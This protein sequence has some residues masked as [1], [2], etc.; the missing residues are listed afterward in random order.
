[1]SLGVVK[2]GVGDEVAEVGTLV[3]GD[4][5]LADI[6]FDGAEGGTGFVFEA[7]EECLYDAFLEVVARILFDDLLPEFGRKVVE[8]LTEDV[9]ADAGEEK[10]YFRPHVLGDTRCGVERDGL[11]GGLNLLLA[12]VVSR[13]ELA[14]GI[15]SINLEALGG[16]GV[17]LDEAEVVKGGA[18]VEK[19]GVKAEVLLAALFGRKEIDA[20]RVVVEQ[21][22]ALL[23]EDLGGFF[24]ELGVGD[25]GSADGEIH[26][27]PPWC[28]RA[29]L[30]RRSL[31]G[32]PPRR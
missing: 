11:P 6:C 2:G 25:R 30:N 26:L 19:F 12:D 31:C 7:A 18:D 10:C 27:K 22:G 21:V 4:V 1:V 23:A 20:D 32:R 16:A 13:E 28:L 3:A 29:L 14:D 24:G 5:A 17:F 15:G 8:A 9:E